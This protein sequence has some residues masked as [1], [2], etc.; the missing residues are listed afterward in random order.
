MN[1]CQLCARERD[2]PDEDYC[3]VC[4]Y[5]MAMSHE[6][7]EYP[8]GVDNLLGWI[9]AKMGQNTLP[10][11]SIILLELAMSHMRGHPVVLPTPIGHELIDF[12]LRNG[13]KAKAVTIKNGKGVLKAIGKI[14]EAIP[15][16]F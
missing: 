5:A 15:K 14:K 16:R 1:P 6:T 3:S 4:C 12:A 10:T 13:I 9:A 8:D 11:I 2:I 7:K